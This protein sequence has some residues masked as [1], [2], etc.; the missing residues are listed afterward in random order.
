MSPKIPF[1]SAS[2]HI[3]ALSGFA[4]AQP[5]FSLLSG[6][7]EFFVA[8][9]SEPVDPIILALILSLGLPSLLILFEGLAK[10]AGHGLHTHVH[11]TLVSV[12]TTAILLQLLKY[13]PALPGVVSVSAAVLLAIMVSLAYLRY[14]PIRTYLTFLAPV[15][16]LFP[17][18]FL[19]NSEVSRIVFPEEVE[20]QMS[21]VEATAPVVMVV[22]DELPLTSL[23]DEQRRIDPV[24]FPNFSRLAGDSYWFRNAT[25]V[26]DSTLL[27]VPAIVSGLSPYLQDP[28]IPT[29]ADYPE[30][31]FTLLGGSYRLEVFENS[32][33]L[34]P[35]PLIEPEK[36]LSERMRSLL[37]DLAIVY[38]HV[39]LPTDLASA[40]PPV[41]RSWNNFGSTT[42]EP[43]ET[44]DESDDGVEAFRTLND[45]LP[46]ADNRAGRFREFIDSIQVNRQPTLFFMHSMLPHTPWEYLPSG[47]QYSLTQSSIPGLTSADS[48]YGTFPAWGN[49]P[50]PMN[51]G[52][53]RHLLQVAFVD[54]LLGDLIDKL[55]EVDLYD[56]SLIVVTADH[57]TSFRTND[58]S[59][60]ISETNHPDIMWIPLFLK[61]PF[62]EEGVVDDRN[63]ETIDIL[64]TMVDALGIDM[65]WQTDG[66]SALDRS[67][68]ERAEKTILAGRSQEF[69]VAPDSDSNSESLQK[70]LELFGSGS[71]DFSFAD[72][73]YTDVLG[74]HVDELGVDEAGIGVELDGESFFEN[75]NLDSS[76]LLTHVTGR[77]AAEPASYPSRHVAVAVNDTVAGVTEMS[78]GANEFSALV[79]ETAFLQG[80]NYVEV[81]FVAEV[82]GT[83]RLERLSRQ[84]SPSY[85]LIDE[86]QAETLQTSNGESI[87]IIPGDALGFVRTE[88]NEESETV[89]I[90]GWAAGVEQPNL[91]VEVLIFQNRQLLY[92]GTPRIVR[93]D[94][95][96]A[97][98]E[99]ASLT[100]GY[101]FGF[102]L[103][104][105]EDREQ[106]E[107]RVFALTP[108]GTASELGYVRDTW[109]FAFSV[110]EPVDVAAETET[111]RTSDGAA[112]TIVPG[113]A[114]GYARAIRSEE[115]ETVVVSGW[116]AGIEQPELGVTILIF[117]NRQLLHSGTPGIVRPDVAEVYPEWASLT[118]GYRFEFPLADF[119]NGEQTE[120]RVFALTPAGTVSELRYIGDTWVFPL[121]L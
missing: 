111:L 34:S 52:Y 101:S 75:V 46:D 84:S 98:P 110:D 89:V 49:D 7:P 79:P 95:A 10:A 21:E 77:I 65:P 41:D 62:Q 94:V 39:L 22:L 70:M 27:S 71:R 9:Q 106:T 57:G 116:A 14:D 100:P 81:F 118:P 103:A 108:A 15:V 115:R 68:P 24:R 47:R 67:S 38:G 91:G 33:R 53:R 112:I 88:R 20:L 93:P 87:P 58:F 73:S 107:V 40:L 104:N 30:T 78:P 96:E 12:L 18:L 109:V 60:R 4:L 5:L 102:P 117:Q 54:T 59:R 66:R 121:G 13:I 83:P 37:S 74:Q 42:P 36:T 26:S 43:V 61:A 11:A 64:P 51:R 113:D 97:Y 19:L 72:S 119:D 86:G 44:G 23:M 55:E 6:Y 90:S 32:T 85:S 28:R 105:F 1:L 16:L 76:F 35:A 17:G 120:V 92:S 25:T 8:R 50:L 99:W 2:L 29:T 3:L 82:D 63:V 31:L 69:V 48:G 45:F 56:R 80:R 114:F